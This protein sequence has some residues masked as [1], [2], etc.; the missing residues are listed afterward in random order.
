M[1]IKKVSS[2]ILLTLS[3]LT[4]PVLGQEFPKY[5]GIP[6]KFENYRT[7][8]C[9]LSPKNLHFDG[10]VFYIRRYSLGKRNITDVQEIYELSID[11]EGNEWIP[12]YPLLY[13]FDL[14]GNGQPDN[15]EILVDIKRDGLNGNDEWG[16]MIKKRMID[17]ST[18][19]V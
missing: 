9:L 8:G 19:K 18:L 1:T 12:Q 5:L 4:M 13:S 3:L 11:K 14:N 17:R 10:D 2:L 16:W 7:K 6:K 15:E